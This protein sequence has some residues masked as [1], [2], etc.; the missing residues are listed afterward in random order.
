MTAYSNEY[1]EEE[2]PAFPED[3]CFNDLSNNMMKL[4]FQEGI[5][6]KNSNVRDFILHAIDGTVE[7]YIVAKLQDK[8]YSSE[9]FEKHNDE[10]V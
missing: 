2:V 8:K 10:E 5:S 3:G 1:L 7:K 6:K 4:K 9:R